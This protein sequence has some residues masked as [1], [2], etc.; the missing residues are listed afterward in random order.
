MVRRTKEEAEAT[1][2]QLLDAAERCFREKGVASTTLDDIAKRAGHTRGAVY[3]HFEN[4]ADI[5]EAVCERVSTPMQAMLSSL[6]AD[7]GND[8]LGYLRNDAIH[9]LR[10]LA[11]CER[12]QS[13]FEI[14]FC[15]LDGGPD[16]DRLRSRELDTHTRCLSMLEVVFAAAVRQG[17]LPM[18]LPPKETAEAMHAFIGGLMRS[19]IERRDFDLRARAP[20]L[21]DTFLTGLRNAPDPAASI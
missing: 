5:F 14:K 18:H 19:W 4:K 13:V 10:M 3:W 12:I 11:E 8:P 16:F 20:W 1:R 9:V 7:P 2:M 6:A 15:K 17:Q 21:V